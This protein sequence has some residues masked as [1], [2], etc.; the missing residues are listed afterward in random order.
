MNSYTLFIVPTRYTNLYIRYDKISFIQYCKFLNLGDNWEDIKDEHGRR[1]VIG[2]F[3]F[4]RR[5]NEGFTASNEC[6]DVFTAME[7][8]AKLLWE[9][10]SVH[11]SHRKITDSLMKLIKK[12]SEPGPDDAPININTTT[13]LDA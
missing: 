10:Y 8:S 12:T 13:P 3:H 2:Q 5:E 11:D 7:L 1:L 4:T 6:R 9:E